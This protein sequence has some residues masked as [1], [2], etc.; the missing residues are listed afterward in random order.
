[1]AKLVLIKKLLPLLAFVSK[2]ARSVCLTET[3]SA[4]GSSSAQWRLNGE[5]SGSSKQYE[6]GIGTYTLNN[7]NNH[8]IKLTGTT[9]SN[10][11]ITSGSL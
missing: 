11:A 5:T 2:Q 10:I 9:N 4:A 1:M 7:I 3:S 6:L 8:P